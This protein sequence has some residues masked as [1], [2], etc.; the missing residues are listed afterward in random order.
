MNLKLKYSAGRILHIL[1]LSGLAFALM[2]QTPQYEMW[3]LAALVIGCCSGLITAL[4]VIESMRAHRHNG[5]TNEETEGQ[6]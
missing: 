2:R 4:L 5:P 3:I 1:C 6:V